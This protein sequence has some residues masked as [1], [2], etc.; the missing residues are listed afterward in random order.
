MHVKFQDLTLS[1]HRLILE[2]ILCYSLRHSQLRAL[3][4]ILLLL[5]FSCADIFI[6]AV[7]S[8]EFPLLIVSN[9]SEKLI[10]SARGKL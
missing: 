7:E 8:Y 2:R 5:F 10:K 6:C 4:H 9:L 1:S 3:L